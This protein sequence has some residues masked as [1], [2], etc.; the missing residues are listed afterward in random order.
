MK[1]DIQDFVLRTFPGAV[2][3]EDRNN[4]DLK[5]HLCADDSADTFRPSSGAGAIAPAFGPRSRRGPTDS[6]SASAGTSPTNA[7][8]SGS[9]TDP[10]RVGRDLLDTGRER[11]EEAA[12]NGDIDVHEQLPWS[13]PSDPR[14]PHSIP[15]NTADGGGNSYSLTI[16][17]VFEKV[18]QKRVELMLQ[19]IYGAPVSAPT[20]PSTDRNRRVQ[21]SAMFGTAPTA[22][23]GHQQQQSR[24]SEEARHAQEV[25]DLLGGPDER[26]G[27]SSSSA[28]IG[29]EAEASSTSDMAA[30]ALTVSVDPTPAPASPPAATAVAPSSPS[31]TNSSD[32]ARVMPFDIVITRS[33][34]DEVLDKVLGGGAE[35][36]ALERLFQNTSARIPIRETTF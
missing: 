18:H 16:R 28:A 27:P 35:T 36:A 33:A 8:S 11:E 19:G 25:R 2:L 30:G 9:P 31:S 6:N 24:S 7:H 1:N 4:T 26:F 17:H 3:L 21:H 22:A 14:L 34:I 12:A 13:A 20:S 29:A 5:F 10:N 32:P 15:L 23:D